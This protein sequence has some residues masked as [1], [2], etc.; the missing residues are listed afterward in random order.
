MIKFTKLH[1]IGNDYLFINCFEEEVAEPAALSRAMSNRHFGAGADGI[2][3]ILRSEVADF[4]M[5]IFNADG[6]EAEMCGNG[7][8]CFSKYVFDHGLT[9]RTGLAVE[10]GAGILTVDLFT[11]G[12]RV[13]S[14]KVDM[15]PPRLDAREI[16]TILEGETIV[17]RE[18]RVA[19]RDY[20]ITLV[21]M[22]NPHCVIYVPNTMEYPVTERGPILEE[23]SLFPRRANIEF[24]EV[25]N[26]TEVRQRTWE[27]GSGETLACGTGAAAVCV[28]GVLTG[29]TDRKLTVHLL[30]GEL[31]LEWVE[32]GNVF[33]TGPAREVYQGIWPLGS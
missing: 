14:V 13:S 8:R 12:G 3:L 6:S 15:G 21:S 23:S 18:V 10:T 2:I 9:E 29:R 26:R 17:D 33:K 20:R 7:L 28:A 32:G 30:G 1:G 27:R 11:E 24:V 22:G 25:M 31:E 5:R 19:G 16:P 4:K